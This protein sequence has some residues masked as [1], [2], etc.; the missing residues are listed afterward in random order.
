MTDA[1]KAEGE[2]PACATVAEQVVNDLP[3]VKRAVAEMVRVAEKSGGRARFG[4]MGPTEDGK[5]GFTGGIGLHT[6]ERFE[7]EIWYSVD[8]EG[9]LGVTVMG[10]DLDLAAAAKRTVEEACRKGRPAKIPR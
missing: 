8:A 5:D 4:G 7:G 3:E 1:R 2:R 10:E 9:H 6:D